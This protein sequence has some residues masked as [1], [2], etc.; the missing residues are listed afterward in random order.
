MIEDIPK[1]IFKYIQE[2]KE[3]HEKSELYKSERILFIIDDL[4]EMCYDIDSAHDF[5]QLKGFPIIELYINSSP[6]DVKVRSIDL[7]SVI[8]RNNIKLQSIYAEKISWCINLLEENI[9]NFSVCKSLISLLSSI[10][11]NCIPAAQMMTNSFKDLDL[12]VKILDISCQKCHIKLFRLIQNLQFTD[13]NLVTSIFTDQFLQRIS[14]MEY[15]EDISDS[16]TDI[17]LKLDQKIIL[18][19][20]TRPEYKSILESIL[21]KLKLHLTKENCIKNNNEPIQSG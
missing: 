7:L 6:I 13:I 10:V 11:T 2:L 1:K 16:I 14:S 5:C 20:T 3:I 18:N 21:E 17:L 15:D 9:N 19:F 12:P 8:L 4:C